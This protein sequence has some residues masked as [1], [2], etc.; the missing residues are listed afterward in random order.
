MA[1]EL[2]PA[3]THATQV[4]AWAA[5]RPGSVDGLPILGA[6]PGWDGLWVATGHFRNGILL[7]PITG[8]LMARSL[9][10]GRE[11]EALSPFSPARFE[12]RIGNAHNG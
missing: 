5:F 12:Q 10:E 3:L 9:L 7:S 6:V 2:V 1:N 4:D 8:R 11:V